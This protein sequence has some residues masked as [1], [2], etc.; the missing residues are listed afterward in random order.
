MI[1]LSLYDS[2]QTRDAYP[3]SDCLSVKA[4]KCPSEQTQDVYSISQQFSTDPRCLF[5]LSAILN[6]PNM[7]ILSLSNSQQTQ[8]VY[9]I[10]QQF[11]IDPR[12]LLYFSAILNRPQMTI[13]FFSDPQQTRDA[14]SVF[15]LLLCDMHSTCLAVFAKSE[16]VIVNT[17]IKF[18]W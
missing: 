16:S 18:K 5:Y 11:S 4:H 12:C 10:S 17:T 2:Q 15:V 13:L 6:R 1:T 14:Y 9:S 7:S 8:D 3:V